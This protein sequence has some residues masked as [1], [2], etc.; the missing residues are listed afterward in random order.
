MG[1]SLRRSWCGLG[2][3]SVS[4]DYSCA[5]YDIDYLQ[6][7]RK[8]G[9]KETLA[10]RTLSLKRTILAISRAFTALP[11]SICASSPGNDFIARLGETE[12]VIQT[13]VEI[14]AACARLAR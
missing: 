10:F 8:R 6:D 3:G 14:C 1:K 5:N 4:I 13:D 9:D 12:A 7:K 2:D 11:T